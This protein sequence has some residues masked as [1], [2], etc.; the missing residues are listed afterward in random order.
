MGLLATVY[1]PAAFGDCSRNGIQRPGQHPL[2]RQRRRPLR[3]LAPRARRDHRLRTHRPPHHRP[4]HPCRHPPRRRRRALPD[5]RRQ[6][7]HR[8]QP[9]PPR[10]P[11][12]RPRPLRARPRSRPFQPG[13]SPLTRIPASL[14]AAHDPPPHPGATLYVAARPNLNRPGIITIHPVGP[15]GGAD[16][17][18]ALAHLPSP[19]LLADCRPHHLP[20]ATA[21]IRRGAVRAP[22]LSI[23]GLL[24]PARPPVDTDAMTR[25]V[26]DCRNPACWRAG[27]FVP[28]HRPT[29]KPFL[30]AS[31][32]VL[33]TTS[34]WV[35]SHDPRRHSTPPNPPPLAIQPRAPANAAQD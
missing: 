21:S 35:S 15:R 1:R 4:V 22:A 33:H 26:M 25:V 7:R 24:L 12:P 11:S 9:L 17:S 30:R 18:H 31:Y 6:L 5:V 20:A 29:R 28:F 16:Y 8:R 2:P 32:A 13:R 23:V 14:A 3:A 27:S 10:P 34:L 19:V